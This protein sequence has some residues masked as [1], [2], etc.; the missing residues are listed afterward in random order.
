[1][2]VPWTLPALRREWNRANA[3][4]APWWRENSKNAYA[5]GLAGLADALRNWSAGR[6]VASRR[7]RRLSQAAAAGLR[8]AGCR[9]RTERS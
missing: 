6:I 1:V 4:V 7:V 3:L 9:S 8:S 2:A 5:S